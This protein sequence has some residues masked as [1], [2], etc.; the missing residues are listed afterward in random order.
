MDACAGMFWCVE[1]GLGCEN[2]MIEKPVVYY[3]LKT[4]KSLTFKF[5]P[6]LKRIINRAGHQTVYSALL[7][8][9]AYQRKETPFWA[10]NIIIGALGY[11]LTPIDSVPDLIPILGFTDDI[12][13]LSF[14]LVTIASY[15]NDDI[16]IKARKGLY[17]FFNSIDLEAVQEVDAR[18]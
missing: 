13:V 17:R 3:M 14:G 7:M 9:H 11:L 15:I 8:Y 10:R 2:F 5:L 16:R 18:L 6:R 4:A 12:S 1:L